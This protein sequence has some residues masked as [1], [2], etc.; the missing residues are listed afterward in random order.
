MNAN[1][2]MPYYVLSKAIVAYSALMGLLFVR[3][4]STANIVADSEF[5]FVSF[6]LFADNA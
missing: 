4:N 5:I 2:A 6:V 3:P 1:T